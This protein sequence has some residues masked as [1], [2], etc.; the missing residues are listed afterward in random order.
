MCHIYLQ[1]GASGCVGC[2]NNVFVEMEE[3]VYLEF[4]LVFA[5]NQKSRVSKT[6]IKSS[7]VLKS[8]EQ[9]YTP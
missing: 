7:S 4:L 3:E 6:N 1:E 8:A 9:T 5:R 2:N